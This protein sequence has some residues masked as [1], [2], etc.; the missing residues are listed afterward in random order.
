VGWIPLI[1]EAAE[2]AEPLLE[3]AGETIVEGAEA[4]AAEA[5]AAGEK[6][7]E[8][9]EAGLVKLQNAINSLTSSPA[10]PVTSCPEA[11]EEA[12]D[13][14]AAAEP[15]ASGAEATAQSVSD[16]LQRYLLNPDHPVGGPKAKWFK[17]ALGFTQ[18]NMEELAKQIKFD[19]SQAVETGVTQYGTKFN[20]TIDVVGAN[21]RQIPVT[22]AWI[23]NSDG[24]V[25]LVTAIPTPK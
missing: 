20:Q 15:A 23:R 8:A 6:I 25:R 3:E 7:V 1:D 5:E 10:S 18:D 17:E 21:G 22:F 16:K 12:D 14:E 19:P 11:A 9:G 2:E 24:V 13:D 4:V